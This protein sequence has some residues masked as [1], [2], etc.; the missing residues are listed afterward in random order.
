ML[1]TLN[2]L[3]TLPLFMT[4]L[5]LSP[6]HPQNFDMSEITFHNIHFEHNFLS[7][8]KNF[9]KSGI[10]QARSHNNTLPECVPDR[11]FSYTTNGN[12]AEAP[13]AAVN[14]DVE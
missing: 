5:D 3:L 4:P 12:L 7:T 11:T 9:H 8:F 1:L 13:A 2:V 14:S 10:G 6:K